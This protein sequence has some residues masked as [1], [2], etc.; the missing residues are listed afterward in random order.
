MVSS[1]SNH[2]VA[3]AANADT[4]LPY[5][6]DD[7]HGNVMRARVSLRKAAALFA[8]AKSLLDHGGDHAEAITMMGKASDAIGSSTYFLSVAMSKQGVGTG[9]NL[10]NLTP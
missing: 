9:P 2:G 1:V 10:R 3:S 4:S 7:V 8:E 5:P 6:D